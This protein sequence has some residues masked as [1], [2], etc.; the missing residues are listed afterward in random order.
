[1]KT[2]QSIQENLFRELIRKEIARVLSE[3]EEEK[4]AENEE[5]ADDEG[6]KK[7]EQITAL[8][9]KFITKMRDGVDDGLSAPNLVIAIT[10]ILNNSGIGKDSKI[11]IIKQVISSIQ[12]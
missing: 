6:A 4:E 9:M 8:V 1:M 5:P 3:A 10:D 2:K 11:M 7:D 12:Q